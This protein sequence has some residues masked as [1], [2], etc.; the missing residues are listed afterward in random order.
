MAFLCNK[1]LYKMGLLKDSGKEIEKKQNMKRLKNHIW[2]NQN[3]CSEKQGN[4]QQQELSNKEVVEE[5]EQ[6]RS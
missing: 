1:G 3:W 2:G 4:K 5:V 6:I